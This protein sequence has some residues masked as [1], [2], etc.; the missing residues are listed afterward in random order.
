M[1]KE[2]QFQAFIRAIKEKFSPQVILLFGSR[3][4]D[5]ALRESDYDVLIVSDRFEGV[6]FTDRLT[7]I[8]RLWTLFEG[9]DC[10]VLTP[11]EY[12]RAREG[13]SLIR[14]IAEEGVPV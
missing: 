3:S 13:I 8:H 6:P 9:L 2:E 12:A 14:L 5:D 7:P 10:L 1:K 11:A 4:R